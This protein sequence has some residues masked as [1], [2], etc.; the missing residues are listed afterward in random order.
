MKH[1]STT[2]LEKDFLCSCLYM[3][4][5]TV[6]MTSSWNPCI[7]RWK[8]RKKGQ[9]WDCNLSWDFWSQ[10][11]LS[12]NNLSW[13]KMTECLK[14]TKRW[15]CQDISDDLKRV[16]QRYNKYWYCW[17]LWC[18]KPSICLALLSC[19]KFEF[20]QFSSVQKGMN[21]QAWKTTDSKICH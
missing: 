18:S 13:D 14:E 19:R 5:A 10:E 15:Y 3:C 4:K 9:V 12:N 16:L 17:E 20:W 8:I 21:K 2:S 11:I 7:S 1:Y 6:Y